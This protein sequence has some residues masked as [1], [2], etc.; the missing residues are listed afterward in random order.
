MWKKLAIAL[1]ERERG[2]EFTA[3]SCTYKLPLYLARV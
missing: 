3:G 1:V 2:I